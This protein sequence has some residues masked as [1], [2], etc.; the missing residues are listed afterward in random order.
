MKSLLIEVTLQQARSSEEM[1][2][3]GPKVAHHIPV[4]LL[5]GGSWNPPANIIMIHGFS[6]PISTEEIDS[7]TIINKIPEFLFRR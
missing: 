2:M 7:H 6:S 5:P 1:K 4:P 3:K